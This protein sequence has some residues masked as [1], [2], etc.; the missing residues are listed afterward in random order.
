MWSAITFSDGLFKSA[1]F[2]N[3]AP[4]LSKVLEQ[5]DFVV[6]VNALHHRRQT[7]HAHAGIDRRLG[8]RMHRAIFGALVLHEH[9]VPDFDVTVAIFLRRSRWP[10]PNMFAVIVEN[11]GAR[12]TRPGITHLPEIVGS[13]T[14]PLIVTDAG[15]AIGRHT[16][17]LLSKCYRLRRLRRKP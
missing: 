14:R 6:A 1:S 17:L 15:N 2:A 10:T 13:V 8:Q 3:A 16:D 11:F 7:L 9:Q 12:P 4:L 5:V